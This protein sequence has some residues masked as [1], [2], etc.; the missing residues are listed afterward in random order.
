MLHGDYHTKNVLMQNGEVLL[1]DMDTIC[2]GNPVFEFASVYLAYVGFGELDH[3]LTHSFMGIPYETTTKMFNDTLRLY[4]GTDDEAFLAD[5][6]DKAKIVGYVRMLRRTIR[7]NGFD[8]EDGRATIALCKS[9]LS[10]LLPR[11][12]SLAF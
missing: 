6:A 5:M 1:I 10:E 9:R 12:S 11:V 3:S 4:F 2:T 7:R 8:T